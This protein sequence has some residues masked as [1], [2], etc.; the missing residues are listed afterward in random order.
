MKIRYSHVGLVIALAL[1]APAQA[2]PTHEGVV[3]EASPA[4]SVH[5][6]DVSFANSGAAA[7]QTAFLSGLALLH[8][9]EYE[10]AAEAFRRAEAADPGFAMAY[11]GEAMTFNHPVWFEQDL[12]AGRAALAK[13]GPTPQARAAKAP[14]QRERDYLAGVEILYGEG[15]KEA[16]DFRYA[17]AMAA[18]HGAYPD[19]VDATALY[20]LSLL[21]TCHEGRDFATYMKS[22]ASKRSIRA[23]CAIRACCT[24]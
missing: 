16:R 24:T 3:R 1:A 23:T 19:D 13:L 9:F 21:G 2:Q 4:D 18:L 6:G 12:V 10:R 20:A 17:D 11:W 15:T 22:A 14:T 5:A 7:A 8:D